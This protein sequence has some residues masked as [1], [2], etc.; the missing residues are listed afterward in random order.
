MLST[1]LSCFS[2]KN[3]LLVEALNQF[4]QMLKLSF[5]RIMRIVELPSVSEQEERSQENYA[6]FCVRVLFDA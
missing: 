1:M 3:A 4:L 6:G 5:R 2:L